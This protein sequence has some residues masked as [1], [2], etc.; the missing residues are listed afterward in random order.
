V[1]HTRQ[2]LE[3]AS[4]LFQAKSV[5][6]EKTRRWESEWIN[7]LEVETKGLCRDDIEAQDIEPWK[8]Q[9]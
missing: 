7:R 6:K 3:E 8:Q 5:N 9:P 4:L 1:D 2:A